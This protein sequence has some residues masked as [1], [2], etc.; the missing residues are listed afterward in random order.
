MVWTIHFT[1]TLI[2]S[3]KE[4]KPSYYLLFI[5][6]ITSSSSSSYKI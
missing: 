3:L 4:N 1:I 2:L 5:I 6:I